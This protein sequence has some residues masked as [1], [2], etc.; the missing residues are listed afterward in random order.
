[1]GV[2]TRRS[3]APLSVHAQPRTPHRGIRREG[4]RRPS[5]SRPQVSFSNAQ[6]DIHTRGFSQALHA[7]WREATESPLADTRTD[8]GSQSLQTGAKPCTSS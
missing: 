3:G 2:E 6:A 7:F 4:N 1:M 5:R 8:K